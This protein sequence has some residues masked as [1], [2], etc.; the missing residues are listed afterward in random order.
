MQTPHL[1]DPI[2][3]EPVGVPTYGISPPN[4]S[5][6][7][8]S[9][10]SS[11]ESLAWSDTAS[12]SS[13][14]RTP[15]S[16]A[17]A[18]VDDLVDKLR[19]LPAA[20]VDFTSNPNK[21]P[22]RASTTL[23]AQNPED[24][25]RILGDSATGTQLIKNC[26]GGGCCLVETVQPDR[27][28]PGS[29]PVVLPDN[30]AFRSLSLKL[31]PL[32]LETEL[33]N[34]PE[35]PPVKISFEGVPASEPQHTTAVFKEPPAFIQPHP[36]YSV[37]SAP[38]HHA[39]ELTK[40]GAEKRTYHFDLD[41]TDYPDEGGVDFKVGGAIGICPPNDP[42]MVDDIFDMLGVPKF[43]RDKPVLMRTAN[44]RWPTIWGDEKPRELVT[45]RREVLTWCSDIQSRPPTKQLLRV[46]AEYASAANEK[47]LL[48]YLTSAQGQA[49][50]C[51]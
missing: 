19:D 8:T 39:R 32:S 42:D 13:A 17:E 24:I 16:E 7:S 4:Q 45:T 34:V 2:P 5:T 6:V 20:A 48:T 11:G 36:P 38:V 10:R 49:A 26:C 46:L 43:V 47:K 50:F 18:D 23:I 21:R 40:P 28:K 14:P 12:D 44:G 27:A 35:L 30:E 29:V 31:T 1:A 15:P 37:F 3:H 51:E 9:P 33:T 41:V 25:R 22:R